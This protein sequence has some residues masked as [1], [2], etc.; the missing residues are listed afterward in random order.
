MIYR[1]PEIKNK[2]TFPV[3]I[4]NS[5]IYLIFYQIYGYIIFHMLLGYFLT[6]AYI[7]LKFLDFDEYLHL[8]DPSVPSQGTDRNPLHSLLSFLRYLNRWRWLLHQLH[9]RKNWLFSN[10]PRGVRGSEIVYSVVEKAKENGLNPYAYLFY[11]FQQLPTI[12][13]TNNAIIQTML[14]WSPSLPD[15]CRVPVK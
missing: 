4:T 2:R 14:P 3:H 8:V 13:L 15:H 5:R 12:D 6:K 7:D 10:T 11:L 9:W 1:K